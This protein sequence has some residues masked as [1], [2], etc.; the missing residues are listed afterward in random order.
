MKLGGGTAREIQLILLLVGLGIMLVLG[1]FYFQQSFH[2]NTS[3]KGVAGML[4]IMF[5]VGGGLLVY[6]ICR[7]ISKWIFK[8]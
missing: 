8:Y 7:P 4:F 1:S 3:S 5:I 2:I 6:G